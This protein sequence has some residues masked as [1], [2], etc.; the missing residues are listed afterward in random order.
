MSESVAT[1]V[2]VRLVGAAGSRATTR[3]GAERDLVVVGDG[4]VRAVDQRLAVDGRQPVGQR[5]VA[6]QR[7]VAQPGADLSEGAVG[8]GEVELGQPVLQHDAYDVA[9]QAHGGRAAAD[10]GG[11]DDARR[12]RVGQVDRRDRGRQAVVRGAEHDGA[13]ADEQQLAARVADDTVAAGV[14]DAGG[15]QERRLVA[16]DVVGQQ[17]ALAHPEQQGAGDLHHV[18]LVDT[19]LLDVGARLVAGRAGGGDRR[20]ARCRRRRH[21]GRSCRRTG[22]RT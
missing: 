9:V 5:R 4:D 18:G 11:V 20:T 13:T 16:G 15:R 21:W 17:L 10:R 7:P 8:V 14:V 6:H 19:E 3:R 2:V 22:R 12:G 1:A